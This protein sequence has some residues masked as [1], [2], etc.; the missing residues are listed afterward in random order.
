MNLDALHQAHKSLSMFTGRP[1]RSYNT[2]SFARAL[3]RNLGKYDL[4]KYD[5]LFSTGSS[6]IAFL[7]TDVPSST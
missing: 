2:I 4:A 1:L 7:R 5:L 6:H 3:A